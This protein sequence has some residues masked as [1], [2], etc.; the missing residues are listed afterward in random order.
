VSCLEVG[1]EGMVG[2]W[3]LSWALV[4]WEGGWMEFCLL[5]FFFVSS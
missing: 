3:D 5:F 2:F 1:E 4:V